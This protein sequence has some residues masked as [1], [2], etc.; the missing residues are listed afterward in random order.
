MGRF[1]CVALFFL[2]LA[3]SGVATEERRLSHSESERY[4]KVTHELIA[5][6]CWREVIAIH[7]S[8]EAL[9]ML[10]EVKQLVIDGRS[11]DEIKAI[12]VARYGVRILA[13]P[14]GSTGQWLYVIPFALLCCFMFLAILRL[15]SLVTRAAPQALQAPPELL[16]RVR[17]ETESEWN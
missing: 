11:E 14:P 16:A 13:D 1:L 7:R 4:D 6:C 10:D 2:S 12:Y 15:R 8:A 9:Q 17:M 3:G 5:P